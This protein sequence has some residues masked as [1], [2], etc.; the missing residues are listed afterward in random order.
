MGSKGSDDEE[1]TLPGLLACCPEAGTGYLDR[2]VSKLATGQ[3]VVA[4]RP[5]EKIAES[6][7]DRVDPK[8][9]DL[10]I[11]LW[12]GFDHLE[13]W[14]EANGAIQL[15][16]GMPADLSFIDR[17]DPVIRIAVKRPF[18]IM[19]LNS[20]LQRGRGKDQIVQTL[21]ML[22]KKGYAYDKRDLQLW[23]YRLGYRQRDVEQLGTYVDSIRENRRIVTG[24]DRLR[25]DI[26]EIWRAEAEE[27]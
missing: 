12:P 19:D 23:A 25:P 17:L 9:A 21:R 8:T 22:H 15:P 6:I 20:G 7:V 5:D 1:Q 2:A 14:L 16:S 27:P 3:S 11:T 13:M 26:L 10:C 18:E 24:S 4:L